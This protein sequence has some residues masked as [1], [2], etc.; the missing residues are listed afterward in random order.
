[1]L[2]CCIPACIIIKYF[3]VRFRTSE[4]SGDEFSFENLY[5]QA[6]QL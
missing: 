5:L 4:F 2:F 6:I 1:M 3:T